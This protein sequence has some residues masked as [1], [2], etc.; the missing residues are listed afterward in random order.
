MSETKEIHIHITKLVDKVIVINSFDNGAKTYDPLL[1]DFSD[2]QQI[3]YLHGYWVKM[4]NSAN[5]SLVGTIPENKTINLMK[6]WNLISYP[7][8]NEKNISDVFGGVMNKII[9]I[10]GYD[11]GEKIYDPLHTN[12]SNYVC[13]HSVGQSAQYL[14]LLWISTRNMKSLQ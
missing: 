9:I 11:H 6:G 12:L 8:D 3:D 10:K 5:L 4:S 13:R 2:L 14:R 1:P 7:C